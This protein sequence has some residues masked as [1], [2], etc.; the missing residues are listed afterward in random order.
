MKWYFLSEADH[1]CRI[2]D[3]ELE[4]RARQDQEE[5]T[6]REALYFLAIAKKGTLQTDKEE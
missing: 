2:E 6:E 3:E 4:F 1:H 5:Q